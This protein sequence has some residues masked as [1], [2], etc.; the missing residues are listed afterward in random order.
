MGLVTE[1]V[2]A[3]ELL[4]KAVALARTIA[5]Y[6]Q[7]SLRTDKQAMLRGWGLPLEEG[8]R[9]ETQLGM[10]QIGGREM[11]E[12]IA[13]FKARPGGAPKP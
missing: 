9:V 1:V 11:G 7:G 13:A 3:S 12:G 8:L 5:A 2:P 10:T 6:P 4:S